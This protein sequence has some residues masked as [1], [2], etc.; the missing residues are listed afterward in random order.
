MI[1]EIEPKAKLER[2]KFGNY[3]RPKHSSNTT[4]EESEEFEGN[5]SRFNPENDL[6]HTLDAHT[7]CVNML[8]VLTGERHSIANG[9][10]DDGENCTG[11]GW[12]VMPDNIY[13]EYYKFFNWYCLKRGYHQFYEDIFECVTMY[14]FYYEHWKLQGKPS[15]YQE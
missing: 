13:G 8:T 15:A 5:E 10:M 4:E 1:I 9:Q 12:Q 6:Q 14:L 11:T 3:L 7:T 2:D